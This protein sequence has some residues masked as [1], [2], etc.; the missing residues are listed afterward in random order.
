ML[1]KI[2]K[3]QLKIKTKRAAGKDTRL[4]NFVAIEF[5]DSCYKI[6]KILNRVFTTLVYYFVI[7]SFVK[8]ST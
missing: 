2:V 4:K 5:I 1:C 7:K 3:S 8:R 6:H